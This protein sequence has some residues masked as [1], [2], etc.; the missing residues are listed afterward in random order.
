MS[1]QI[2]DLI[3]GNIT[4]IMKFFFIERTQGRILVKILKKAR[5][6]D[7]PTKTTFSTQ[8]ANNQWPNLICFVL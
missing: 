6:T 2:T 5:I 1:F 3:T 7:D 8:F 4:G